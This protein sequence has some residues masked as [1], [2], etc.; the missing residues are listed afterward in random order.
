MRTTE[1]TR[2]KL[3]RIARIIGP[4]SAAAAALQDM[5]RIEAEGDYALCVKQGSR[6]VVI[7]VRP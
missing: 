7:R 6:L 2:E 3:L 1:M 5:D 4:E